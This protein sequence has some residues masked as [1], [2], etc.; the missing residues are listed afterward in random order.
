MLR[1]KLTAI[2]SVAG[3]IAV[4]L[5]AAAQENAKYVVDLVSKCALWVDWPEYVPAV[6]W[7]GGCKKGRADGPG[8][9]TFQNSTYPQHPTTGEA[10]FVDGK[11]NGRGFYL[12][13]G[14]SRYEGTFRDGKMEG[15]GFITMIRGDAAGEKYDGEFRNDKFH[16]Q[17]V[18]TWPNG[19]RL[20]ATFENDNGKGPAL[21]RDD[22]GTVRRG[23]LQNRCFYVNGQL[24][25]SIYLAGVTS[26]C[27]SYY[28]PD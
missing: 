1:R 12:R 11:L 23:T 18:Y 3:V 27:R 16:G 21:Y 4:A 22:S 2:A 10:T 20:E 28:S 5:P 9:Y 15:R 24:F 8:R 14:I 7:E 13:V 17:G 6:R 19:A 25:T 26:A